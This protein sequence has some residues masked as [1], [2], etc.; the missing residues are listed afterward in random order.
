VVRSSQVVG[1]LALVLLIVCLVDPSERVHEHVV[2]SRRDVAHERHEKEGHLQDGVLDEVDAVNYIG[3]PC[4]LREICKEA[5]ELNEDAD[6]DSLH[7]MSECEALVLLNPQTYRYSHKDSNHYARKHR[8]CCLLVMFAG[9]Q[10]W[11]LECSQGANDGELSAPKDGIGLEVA[12]L[13]MRVCLC[14]SVNHWELRRESSQCPV[15]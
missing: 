2:E 3:V 13:A 15:A 12:H 4:H 9:E 7:D 1:V 5:E 6:A 14:R 8:Q 11:V 10:A